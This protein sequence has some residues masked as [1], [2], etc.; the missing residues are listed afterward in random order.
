M[1]QEI[2]ERGVVSEGVLDEE[3]NDEKKQH[4]E[5]ILSY[6]LQMCSVVRR[7]SERRF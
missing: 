1:G 2:G 4:E 7:E 3:L 5:Y 6:M